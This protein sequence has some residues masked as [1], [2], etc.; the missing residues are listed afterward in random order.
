MQAYLG[1]PTPTKKGGGIIMTNVNTVKNTTV[2]MS[3]EDFL[4]KLD[5]GI[6]GELIE[7][8]MRDKINGFEDDGKVIVFTIES[9]IEEVN[10]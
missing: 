3:A 1:S 2:M 5:L 9:E 10:I 8:S 4:N 6:D 7:I